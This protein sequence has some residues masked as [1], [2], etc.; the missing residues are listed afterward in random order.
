MVHC[1]SE[2]KCS[3][4]K[5]LSGKRIALCI[6]G[7]VGAVR[8]VEIARLLM[9]HGAEVYPVMSRSALS[10]VG[11]DLLWWATGNEPVTELTGKCEH[12]SLCGACEG[13]VDLLLVAPATANT[14]AKAAYGMDD[15][16]VTTMLATAIGTGIPV[17]FAPAMHATM[18]NSLFEENMRKLEKVAKAE[19]ILPVFEEGKAKEPAADEIVDYCIRALSEKNLKGRRILVSAGATREKIDDVRFISNPSSGKMGLAFAREAWLRG[20]GVVLVKAHTECKIPRYLSIID[21]ETIEEM[22]AVVLKETR[23]S[24]I[25]IMAAAIGDFEVKSPARGKIKSE[26]KAILALSLAPVRKIAE[27][28]KKANPK[29]RLILFKAES[30]VSEAELKRRAQERMKSARADLV[31]ANDVSEGAF[32]GDGCGVL[33]VSPKGAGRFAGSKSALA[34][35]VLKTF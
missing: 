27:D 32:G 23:K 4:G 17:I 22:R 16:P 30:K 26:K 6:C 34:E 20:A 8:S 28:I 10:L 5:R 21:A 25:V 1:S 31:I 12:V 11:K 29:C 15:T 18:Y 7:S 14:V 3:F 35:R 13:K 2:I 19:F 33:V 9:R 24:D